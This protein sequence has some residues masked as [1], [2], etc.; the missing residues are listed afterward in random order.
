[1]RQRLESLGGRDLAV[2]SLTLEEIFM[3]VAKSGG[4]Q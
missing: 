3:E 1:M 2:S 4:R